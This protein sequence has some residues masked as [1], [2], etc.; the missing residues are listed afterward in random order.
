MSTP[1]NSLNVQT[2]KVSQLGSISGRPATS[3]HISDNDFF[4]LIQSGSESFPSTLYSR[5]VP[6]SELVSQI[7]TGVYS[8]SFSGSYFGRI[9]SKNTKATGSFS[10][11][12]KGTHTGSFSGS[13]KGIVSGSSLY[14]S[15]QKV[16]F[17]GTASSAKTVTGNTVKFS[18]TSSYASSSRSS[19][20]LKYTGTPNGT[21]SYSIKSGTSISAS[22]ARTASYSPRTVSASYAKTSSFVNPGPLVPKAWVVFDGRAGLGV[23]DS[24]V[25]EDCDKKDNMNVTKVKKDGRGSYQ[26][27]MSVALSNSNYCVVGMCTAQNDGSTPGGVCF[28]ASDL[29]KKKNQYFRVSTHEGTNSFNSYEVSVLVFGR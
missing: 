5:K 14:N 25:I 3:N 24:T 22:Y 2:I 15:Q 9:I 19:S 6:F 29:S 28:D 17:Y 16:S 11:N 7:S 18:F 20:F 10:G 12:F 4:L 21:S 26:I 1:C 8:G 23:L 13:F 27:S